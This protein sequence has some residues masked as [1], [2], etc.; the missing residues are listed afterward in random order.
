MK[1]LNDLDKMVKGNKK[2]RRPQPS[3]KEKEKPKG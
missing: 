3:K 1:V 2:I